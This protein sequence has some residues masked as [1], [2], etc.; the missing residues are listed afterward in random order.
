VGP[1]LGAQADRRSNRRATGG[2]QRPVNSSSQGH[3]FVAMEMAHVNDV[4]RAYSSHTITTS[5]YASGSSA[6]Y[7]AIWWRH[8]YSEKMPVMY[9]LALLLPPLAVLLCGKPFQ[10]ILNILLTILGWIPGA[11]HA[12]LVAHN[13]YADKR[14]ERIMREMRQPPPER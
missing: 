2:S 7:H 6:A 11:V 1:A 3:R 5:S 12:C 4:A 9:L 8:A 14:T 13:Y 10:A